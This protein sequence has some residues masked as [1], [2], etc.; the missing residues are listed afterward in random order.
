MRFLYAY[1]YR[2]EEWFAAQQNGPSRKEQILSSPITLQTSPHSLH[3]PS[4]S[5]SSSFHDQYLTPT[6]ASQGPGMARSGSQQS[7]SSICV[8]PTAVMPYTY[9]DGNPTFH[10]TASIFPNPRRSSGPVRTL[11]FDTAFQ[12][13]YKPN[14][15][16]TAS[17]R[18]SITQQEQQP[19]RMRG[20]SLSSQRGQRTS[21]YDTNMPSLDRCDGSSGFD[22]GF[23]PEEPYHMGF[24]TPIG[25][26]KA[27]T[28]HNVENI[29]MRMRDFGDKPS[30]L[31]QS[32]DSAFPP[33]T[34]ASA[35]L[36]NM[37]GHMNTTPAS[38]L[39]PCNTVDDHD[40]GIV[41]LHRHSVPEIRVWDMDAQTKEI[42][43]FLQNYRQQTGERNL[44]T[45]AKLHDLV[46][47]MSSS[48]IGTSRV[49]ASVHAGPT[50][51][52]EDASNTDA[53]RHTDMDKT[54]VKC[55]LCGKFKARRSDLKKHMKR[56]EKPY[57][58]TFQGCFKKFGSKNDWKRHEHG[59]HEQQECWTCIGDSYAS[60]LLGCFEAFPKQQDYREHL[61]THHCIRQKA[62][63]DLRVR[64]GRV[65]KR[66]QGRY[67]CG[68]CSNIITTGL[69]GI[70]GENSRFDHIGNHFNDS[71][72]IMDWIELGAKGKTKQ[73]VY[74]AQNNQRD[75]HTATIGV[76]GTRQVVEEDDE[77]GDDDTTPSMST[78][79]SLSPD[80]Q[81]EAVEHRRTQSQTAS[82]VSH[83]R[84]PSMSQASSAASRQQS[85]YR[86][87]Q[88]QQHPFGRRAS[89]SPHETPHVAAINDMASQNQQ[90]EH[91]I[92]AFPPLE[93][94]S[95]CCLC[96]QGGYPYLTSVQHGN[97]R[98]EACSHQICSNCKIYDPNTT[99]VVMTQ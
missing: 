18:K 86:M 25:G 63:E 61:R 3:R 89:L 14:Q 41:S 57:G 93:L 5:R 65:A 52:M 71:K 75:R 50:P 94:V 16:G 31:T 8:S 21:T 11:G 23:L 29:G 44:I 78:N 2:S 69:R 60:N 26:N 95:Q 48:G 92:S 19:K 54:Q 73:Q 64:G 42:H 83:S 84:P 30:Q 47:L 99:D 17:K 27:H 20:Q 10:D 32:P 35:L 15:Q 24:S 96:T 56:H 90:S 7:P 67:W 81:L 59:Q 37:G 58:C 66:S 80:T 40:R 9:H 6:S 43:D 39:T 82:D 76:R 38:I 74:D 88:V 87:L 98:C 13:G 34:S 33:Q 68:F 55:H 28:V 77:D 12:T 36:N 70:P 53:I 22:R 85:S 4:S 91:Q 62:E 51:A 97:G 45:A 79:S 1:D 46:P 72:D 49:A